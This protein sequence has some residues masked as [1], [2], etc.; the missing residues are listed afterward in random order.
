MCSSDLVPCG[1]RGHGV[2]SLRDLGV[3]ATMA[4]VDAA[5]KE[6]FAAVFGA[7]QTVGA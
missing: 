5:L 7:P 3:K 4:D 2:T 6:S 1:V